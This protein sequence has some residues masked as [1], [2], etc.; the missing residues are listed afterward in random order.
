[1]MIEL[2]A[3][4]ALAFAVAAVVIAT[5]AFTR[6]QRRL[7]ALESGLVQTSRERELSSRLE[8]LNWQSLF[9]RHGTVAL[10]LTSASISAESLNA[11]LS[12]IDEERPKFIVELGSGVSTIYMARVIK[13]L[14]IDATITSIEGDQHWYEHLLK[15]LRA[16]DL[17]AIVA[18]RHVPLK[19]VWVKQQCYAWYDTQSLQDLHGVDLLLVDGPPAYGEFVS[20]NRLPAMACLGRCLAPGAVV[21]L[22]DAN[23]HGERQVLQYWLAHYRGLAL[24]PL[25]GVE[26]LAALRV[27]DAVVESAAV[28]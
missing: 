26:R 11:V 2:L 4:A 17:D 6:S 10:P 15:H 14:G 12:F 1:M 24:E 19:E 5:F 23:R 21:M 9:M 16:E 18:L 25:P 20:T 28:R 13:D 27:R 22:D 7:E 3:W 8:L